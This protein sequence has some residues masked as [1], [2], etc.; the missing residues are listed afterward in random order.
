MTDP[1]SWPTVV[2]ALVAALPATVLAFAT[3][4]KTFRIHEDTNSNLTKVTEKLA[5]S[6]ARIQ[7]LQTRIEGLLAASPPPPTKP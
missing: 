6:D 2:V 7:V 5:D 3:L 1:S 4:L